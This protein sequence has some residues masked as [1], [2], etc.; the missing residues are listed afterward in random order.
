MR[1][2]WR[3]LMSPAWPIDAVARSA[4]RT[5]REAVRALVD[6]PMPATTTS[7][8]SGTASAPAT[9]ARIGMRRTTGGSVSSRRSPAPAP[10]PAFPAARV[11]VARKAIPAPLLTLAA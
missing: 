7:A 9:L 1:S 3:A 2:V 6:A 4:W 5:T 11:G 8:R 10:T